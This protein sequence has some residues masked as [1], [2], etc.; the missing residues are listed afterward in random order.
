MN[1]SIAGHKSNVARAQRCKRRKVA[2]KWCFYNG[3]TK[4]TLGTKLSRAGAAVEVHTSAS[5]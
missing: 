5:R 1:A 2:R 3:H 4:A